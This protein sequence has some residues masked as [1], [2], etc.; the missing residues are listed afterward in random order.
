MAVRRLRKYSRY[1][2]QVF[3]HVVENQKDWELPFFGLGVILINDVQNLV[4]Q[5]FKGF[6]FLIDR[7][8]LVKL[9]KVCENELIWIHEDIG[10]FTGCTSFKQKSGVRISRYHCIFKCLN[11]KTLV[12]FV[13]QSV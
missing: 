1:S 8:E 5:I 9:H 11:E 2:A 13:N 7:L 6:R 4:F 3:K 12:F 10:A